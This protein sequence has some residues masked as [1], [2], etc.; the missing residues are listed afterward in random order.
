M[1]AYPESM[2]YFLDEVNGVSTNIFRL[3]PQNSNEAVGNRIRRF[4]LPANSLLNLRSFKLWFACSTETPANELGNGA[5]GRLPAGIDRLIQRVEVTCGGVQLSAGSNYYNVLRQAKCNLQ[6]NDMNAEL[7]H[8]DCV[9]GVQYPNNGN[10][11]QDNGLEAP[12]IGGAN[13]G[14]QDV[15]RPH[16]SPPIALGNWQY[17]EI[18]VVPAATNPFGGGAVDDVGIKSCERYSSAN[19]RTPFCVD[20]WEGFLGSCEPSILDSSLLP[21][22]VISI[23]LDDDS[24]LASVNGPFMAGT[25]NDHSD[26]ADRWNYRCTTYSG[27]PAYWSMQNIHATI[28]CLG[29]SDGVLDALEASIIAQEGSLRIPFKQYF[30]FQDTTSNTLRFNVA[31]QS[32]DRIWVAHRANNYALGNRCGLRQVLGTKAASYAN[33]IVDEPTTDEEALQIIL[34]PGTCYYDSGGGNVVST[35]KE[36]YNTVKFDM[37]EPTPVTGAQPRYQF[38]LNASFYPQFQAT[39]E[40]MVGVSRNS[41]EGWREDHVSLATMRNN[42]ST[43]CIR[44]CLPQTGVRKISGFDTR[45]VSLNGYYNLHNVT[46]NAGEIPT[47]NLFCECTSVLRIGAARQLEVVQ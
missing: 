29:L 5:G 18:L 45:S 2:R 21:D 47:I 41:V 20:K 1:S 7:N 22:I 46:S 38:S 25:G 12:D 16:Y 33:R 36:Q 42:F 35:N 44:L 10:K 9:R 11:D 14:V 37:R 31:T 40:E 34:D 15:Q 3:E 39:Y 17:P 24:P 30:S 27:V 28:E 32:L 13:T 43:Q 6:G 23:F 19:Y 8:P 4:T 26:P